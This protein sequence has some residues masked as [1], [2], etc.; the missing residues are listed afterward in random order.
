LK[1]PITDI[2]HSCKRIERPRRLRSKS[3]DT[4]IS[5]I[6]STC[7]VVKI[8]FLHLNHEATEKVGVI[9]MYEVALKRQKNVIDNL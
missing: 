7:E 3:N 1:D 4:R 8:G 2:K 6:C 5:A 9:K